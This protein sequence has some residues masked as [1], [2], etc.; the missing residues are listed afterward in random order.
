MKLYKFLCPEQRT[1]YRKEEEG[2]V[3]FVEDHIEHGLV[4][5]YTNHDYLHPDMLPD[6]DMPG[7]WS[8]EIEAR[9]LE[10]CSCG[11]HAATTKGII[12][13]ADRAMYEVQL[14]G[15]ILLDANGSKAC[16]QC[17][18]F[19]RRIDTWNLTTLA[20]FCLWCVRSNLY[21]LMSRKER[22]AFRVAE[23]HLEWYAAPDDYTRAHELMYHSSDSYISP[24]SRTIRALLSSNVTSG[25][26]YIVEDVLDT[27]RRNGASQ[28]EYA[29][30]EL[31]MQRKLVEMLGLEWED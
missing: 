29:T 13:W 14:R 28:E 2:I 18:R 15:K 21:S 1:I 11:W 7:M 25:V 27:L 23:K 12:R 22:W 17:I 31:K 8:Y 16:G 26:Q 19:L 20:G 3:C 4:G 5:P 10:M 9:N 24:A 30:A 6:G